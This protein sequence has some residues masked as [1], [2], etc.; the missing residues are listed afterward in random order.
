MQIGFPLSPK[1]MLLL[2]W[3]PNVLANAVISK[4][5]VSELN[6]AR[7][8]NAERFLY[9]HIYDKRIEKLAAQFRDAKPGFGFQ[10]FGPKKIC[11]RHHR[12]DK[13]K[14]AVVFFSTR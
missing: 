14:I 2:T 9:A 12:A 4:V 3:Q 7:A 8:A 11:A 6:R 5:F 13:E 10:G 1:A